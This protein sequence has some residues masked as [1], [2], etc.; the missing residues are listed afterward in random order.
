MTIGAEAMSGR[1]FS[2]FALA[3]GLA[4]AAPATAQ[5]QVPDEAFAAQAVARPA[6]PAG[7]G[8]RV[9]IDEAHANF[10]TAEGGYRA[11]AGLMRADGAAVEAGTAPFTA[12]GLAGVEVLVIVNAGASREPGPFF[13]EAEI[14]AVEA[15]VREG[16]ALLLIADHAPFGAAARDLAARFGVGMGQGWVFE[17]TDAAPWL[18]T[19]ILF[20]REDGRL[21][22][23]PILAGRGPDEA[24]AAVKS[25]SGQSLSG[26]EGAAVLLRLSPLALEAPD[27]AALQA[28]A[29][30]AAGPDGTR[31]PA[32][33]GHAGPPAG[34]A[35]GLAFEHGRGRVVVLGEAAMLT[36]QR[37][38]FDDGRPDMLFGMNTPGH[39]NRQFALN[40]M[41]WLA[42]ALD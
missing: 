25:F 23:H 31:D 10:H 39:D 12:A 32:F 19:Q 9:V 29:Q 3:L 13:A 7:Q 21:G 2:A 34:T 6:W 24:V 8:P 22:E 1:L 5:Q 30:A 18:T 16:G 40:V 11:F 27:A 41:R 38:R 15:W 35:Q 28:A 14:A 17:P 37:I 4:L 36:A 20:T 33:G 42:R 26:P